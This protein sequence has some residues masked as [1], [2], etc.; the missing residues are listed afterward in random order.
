[1]PSKL[2]KKLKDFNNAMGQESLRPVL[3][4]QRKVNETIKPKNGD[5]VIVANTRKP[6]DN[7]IAPNNKNQVTKPANSNEKNQPQQNQQQ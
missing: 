5:N 6:V 1:M 7:K 4:N 3:T 2:L